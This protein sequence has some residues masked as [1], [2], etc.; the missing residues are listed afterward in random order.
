MRKPPIIIANWKMHK[1]IEE[2][3]QFILRLAPKI[4][5]VSCRVLIA[6]PFTAI[7][8]SAEAA[9]N[10]NI[11]IGAQN[12][13][14][15]K[16]GAFTGEISS[17]LLINAGAGFVILG[18]SERRQI[19]HE[20][21]TFIHYKLKQAIK[22][23]LIPILCIGET[24]KQHEAENTHEVLVN[25][26]N[27]A[28]EGFS[29]EELTH[30]ILAYEP[31]WAIGTGKTATPELAQK[32]HRN[33]RS[34]IARKWGNPLAQNLPILYGGSVKPNNIIDLLKELDIDGALIG[35]ASLDEEM[36]AQMVLQGSKS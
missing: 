32:V 34:Y 12:M 4:Q 19:F 18:H 30:C 14:D 10:T 36:F 17:S 25:Q 8:A 16:E 11:V 29:A 31:I 28:L 6:P 23:K 13:H 24:Q 7:A 21:D 3:K 26:I 35:G 9:K 33:I 2:A 22:N 15:A 20:T 1:T 27:K 5:K